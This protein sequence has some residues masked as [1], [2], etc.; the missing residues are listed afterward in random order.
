MINCTTYKLFYLGLFTSLF[1][2]GCADKGMT[3]LEQYVNEI[4]AIENLHV[5]EIPEYQHIPPYFY[6][7]Q[8]MRNPF[9]PIINNARNPNLI[10]FL[11]NNNATDDDPDA[12]SHH[13][14]V[15]RVRVGL[16]LL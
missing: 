4:K 13:P 6:A 7:V 15:N 1:F 16:E 10:D 11:G 14:N 9:L 2:V 12:C 5:D 8:D 3:D